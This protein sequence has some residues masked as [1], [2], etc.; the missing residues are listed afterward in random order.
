[1]AKKTKTKNTTWGDNFKMV[2][3]KIS[4]AK[5]KNRYV[6]EPH[7]PKIPKATIFMDGKKIILNT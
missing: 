7:V 4:E 3:E 6:E 2:S 5:R 1:M